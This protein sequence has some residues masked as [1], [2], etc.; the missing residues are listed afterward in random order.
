MYLE[1]FFWKDRQEISDLL[2]NEKFPLER[3]KNSRGYVSVSVNKCKV[4]QFI[5]NGMDGNNV[6]KPW[7]LEYVKVAYTF[8]TTV[9]QLD[10]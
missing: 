6:S 10:K 1:K 9:E 5:R 4:W 7:T 8:W 2:F 3:K